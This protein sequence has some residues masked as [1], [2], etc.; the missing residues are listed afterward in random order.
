MLLFQI[1][2][3]SIGEDDDGSILLKV[4]FVQAGQPMPKPKPKV[5]PK[6]PEPVKAPEPVKPPT[7][8][9]SMKDI[10]SKVKPPPEKPKEV[11][12]EKPKP[13]TKQEKQEKL[14]KRDPFFETEAYEVWI[15]I[16]TYDSAG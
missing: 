9:P 14:K 3:A 15:E 1:Y 16:S 12:K 11:P 13:E 6:P 8:K 7:P 2:T 5:E 10:V 4:A